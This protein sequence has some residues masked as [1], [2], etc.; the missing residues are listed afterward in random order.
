M[1]FGV[2]CGTGA[3]THS[4]YANFN[5]SSKIQHSSSAR[6]W[7]T[8]IGFWFVIAI[9]ISIL[10]LATFF[11]RLLASQ[12]RNQLPW[13]RVLGTPFLE[14]RSGGFI[15]TLWLVTGFFI[16][17][18]TGMFSRKNLAAIFIAL[19]LTLGVT[20]VW[21]PSLAGGDLHAWQ[22]FAAPLLLLVATRLN[23][24]RW[25]NGQL[26]Y[27]RALRFCG[28]SLLALV[29]LA[30]CVW[31]RVAEIPDVGEP[32]DV[33]GF[34]QSL[35]SLEKDQASRAIRDAMQ[36]FTATEKELAEPRETKTTTIQAIEAGDILAAVI[37]QSPPSG[38][39]P[40]TAA[41]LRAS[42]ERAIPC[43]PIVLPAQIPCGIKRRRLLLYHVLQ[44][45]WQGD[46]RELEKPL[47]IFFAKPWVKHLHEAVQLPVGASFDSGDHN[48]QGQFAYDLNVAVECLAVR[49][50]QLQAGGQNEAALE[51]LIDALRLSRHMRSNVCVRSYFWGLTGEAAALNGIQRWLEGLAPDQKLV[52]RASEELRLH[53]DSLPPFHD[54]LKVEYLNILNMFNKAQIQSSPLDLEYWVVLGDSIFEP[55]TQLTLIW[56]TPCERK[57]F[58]RIMNLLFGGWLRA[59]QADYSQIPEH[60]FEDQNSPD[61]MVRLWIGD[62]FPPEDGPGSSLTAEQLA[63]FMFLWPV[64]GLGAEARNRDR[65]EWT[66]WLRATRLIVALALYQLHEHKPAPSLEA[67]IPKYLSDLPIDPY[68]GKPFRYRISKGEDI[69]EQF[70]DDDRFMSSFEPKERIRH[71]P[72]GQGILW[73]V[74]LDGVDNGGVKHGVALD[75]SEWA[76]QGLDLIFVAPEWPKAKPN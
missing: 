8:C 38:M 32:F 3:F 43:L 37:G 31:F 72:E 76:S 73:S 1:V 54:C 6:S 67:L 22:A 65:P 21:I 24:R 4:R 42:K 69:T 48:E 68:S 41:F 29:C 50:L 28:W 19:I 52:R 25:Q 15:L 57:R 14:F 23:M 12:E 39:V 63:H 27:G 60:H 45:G 61:S 47:E 49:A 9:T 40:F 2:F 53:E 20:T 75:T 44:N 35:S 16:G 55:R 66:C 70:F 51:H 7:L 46:Q 58:Q 74:G 59:C 62:W 71:V 11:L 56:Q 64:R 10:I 18:F 13:A 17:Q 34:R 26:K 5:A 36:E 30:L 33:Q